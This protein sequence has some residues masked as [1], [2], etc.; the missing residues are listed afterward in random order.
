M[1]AEERSFSLLASDAQ[2]SILSFLAIGELARFSEMSRG[3][4]RV[5]TMD[6]LWMPFL[7]HHFGDVVPPA[8]LLLL[9]PA[10]RFSALVL[11]L[12]SVCEKILLPSKPRVDPEWSRYSASRSYGC[13]E[14]LCC[15]TCHCQCR[16]INDKCDIDAVDEGH[17]DCG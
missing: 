6:R 13:C 14:R 17:D 5:A 12:C 10:H 1:M 16:C 8:Y 4:R 11:T 7:A 3:C 9:D 15:V 2:A